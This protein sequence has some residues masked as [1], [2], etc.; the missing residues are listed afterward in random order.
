MKTLYK[1]FVAFLQSN[2]LAS[3]AFHTFYQAFLSVFLLGLSPVIDLI[4]RGHVNDAKLALFSLVGGGI[5]AGLSAVK[6]KIVNKLKENNY[7]SNE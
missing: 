5:A 1:K 2:S 6:T 7:G 3:K 4:A